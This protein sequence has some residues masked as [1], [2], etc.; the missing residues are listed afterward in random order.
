MT[1][2]IFNWLPPEL[3]INVVA[4]LQSLQD[5]RSFTS[6]SPVARRYFHANQRTSFLWPYILEIHANFGDEALVPLALILLQ[7]RKIEQRIRPYLDA[8]TRFDISESSEEWKTNLGC[9][10]AIIHMIREIG[11]I[12][13]GSVNKFRDQMPRTARSYI[14]SY[15]DRGQVVNAYLR[16]DL[17]CQLA[18]NGEEKLF[19]EREQV[20]ELESYLH[21]H[22]PQPYQARPRTPVNIL[23]LIRQRHTDILFCVDLTIGMSRSERS[24]RNQVKDI[25]RRGGPRPF[26]LQRLQECRFM[27]RQRDDIKAYLDYVSL[28]GYPFLHYLEQL[29]PHAQKACVLDIFFKI[30]TER[31]RE[32]AGIRVTTRSA[33]KRAN[34]Y[35]A[36]AM[37]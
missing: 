14:H 35:Q 25:L 37:S 30:T 33:A 1:S 22:L 13:A 7:V 2:D 6:A 26:V 10:A 31:L 15:A 12:T 11:P 18:C 27:K 36:Y 17:Y 4:N 34:I 21:K 24:E 32:L 8:V 28:Q 9:I 20:K 19:A 16:Y 29:E 5:I 3:H 23:C